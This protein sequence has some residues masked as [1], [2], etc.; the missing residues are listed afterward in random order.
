MTDRTRQPAYLLRKIERLEAELAAEKERAEK[1]WIG[2]RDCLYEL[3]DAQLTIKRIKA[4]LQ[5]DDK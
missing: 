4:A 5:G 3:T 2:Y 1:A